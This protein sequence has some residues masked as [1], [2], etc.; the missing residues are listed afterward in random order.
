[1]SVSNIESILNVLHEAYKYIEFKHKDFLNNH[2][3]ITIKEILRIYL[4][5]KNIKQVVDTLQNKLAIYI[6]FITEYF[7]AL[8]RNISNYDNKQYI[9]ATYC[10]IKRELVPGINI[11]VNEV[12]DENEIPN[13]E[14]Y[15][16]KNK[17]MYGIKIHNQMVYGNLS[18]ITTG[19]GNAGKATESTIN[20]NDYIYRKNRLVGDK[21]TLVYDVSKLSTSQISKQ[22]N[23]YRKCL[24]HDLLVYII[25]HTY[26]DR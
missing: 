19:Y 1:M 11:N 26:Y 21:Q 14:I 3:E 18:D 13:S 6:N 25:L 7:S 12:Q 4:V 16:I 2:N 8:N 23:I 5:Y 24:I 9:G 15:Y 17:D 22:K 20:L 10:K